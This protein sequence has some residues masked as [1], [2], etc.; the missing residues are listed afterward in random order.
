MRRGSSFVEI[1]L[2]LGILVVLGTPLFELAQGGRRS[3][4]DAGR[5]VEML[6]AARRADVPV[7]R[8]GATVRVRAARPEAPDS[9]APRAE[10][11]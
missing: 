6:A 1:A 4:A 8:A 2:A 11:P 3:A 5:L 9:W 7:E 10:A